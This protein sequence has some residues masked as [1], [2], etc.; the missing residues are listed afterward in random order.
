VTTQHPE[1]TGERRVAGWQRALRWA[2]WLTFLAL[3]VWNSQ[4]V[5]FSSL[6]WLALAAAVGVSIWCLAKPLG[7]PLFEFV[8]PAHLQG[9]FVSRTNWGLVVFG[10]ILT[11]GGA[12]AAVAI[13]YDV[14]TGRATLKDVM[15]DIGVFTRGWIGELVRGSLY[16]AELEKT[17][18]YILAL[19]LV[20]GVLLVWLNLIPFVKRGRSWRVE[21]D[22]SVSIRRDGVWTPLLEQDHPTVT[23]DGKTFT[24]ACE[25]GPPLV[26]P[27]WRVYSEEF[28]S[29]LRSDV[30]AKFFKQRLTGRGFIVDEG[31]SARQFV[32]RRT[33]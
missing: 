21:L 17:R 33:A 7:G 28:G 1:E 32:A 14:S 20:P 9:T 6:E 18:A 30:S 3:A 16:D 8:E 15:V 29:R 24:F 4:S 13:G 26:L 5:Y 2:A 23:A 31:S 25:D 12:A 11:S 19:L 22:R 10:A 27:Q